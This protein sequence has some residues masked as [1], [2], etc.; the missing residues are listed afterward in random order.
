MG[1]WEEEQDPPVSCLPGEFV[2]ICKDLVLGHPLPDQEDDQDLPVFSLPGED[3]VFGHLL[4]HV[5]FSLP[6]EDLVFG[7][8]LS[9]VV[10]SLPGEDM[11][12]GHP[13][14]FSH[15]HGNIWTICEDFQ[16]F[17]K[18]CKDLVLGHP[19]H[20]TYICIYLY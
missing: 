11:V 16:R 2:K 18:F 20:S 7:H 10:F 5:V 9:H 4:S 19:L 12:F 14:H 15:F 17:V 13:L 6:C 8:P 3:L 1:T